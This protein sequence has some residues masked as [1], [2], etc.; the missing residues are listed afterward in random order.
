MRLVERLA[1]EW[2]SIYDGDAWHGT[3]IKPMLANVDERMAH[4]RPI[5]NARTIAE[6]VAHAS[7]WIAIVERRLRG[8]VFEVTPEMDF[9]KGDAMPFAELLAQMDAHHARL[10]ETLRA[11]PD[12]TL[13]ELVPGKKQTHWTTLTGLAHHTT[14]HA[15][16]IAILKKF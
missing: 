7:A 12:A 6:L 10:L 3:S 4:A 15:A 9:P 16:Q 14:Y 8:E 2:A 11:T 1:A 13:D 5:E